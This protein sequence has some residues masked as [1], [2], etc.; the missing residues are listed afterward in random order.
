MFINAW[1]ETYWRRLLQDNQFAETLKLNS[2]FIEVY[3]DIFRLNQS[4]TCL[5]EIY[6]VQSNK[7]EYGNNYRVF[8]LL[9]SS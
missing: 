6:R 4:E 1:K 9:D 3:R 7:T 2:S 5:I 8:F